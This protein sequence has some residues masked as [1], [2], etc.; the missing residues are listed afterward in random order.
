[1]LNPI[2]DMEDIRLSICG[3]ALAHPHVAFTLRNES[4]GEK[5]IQTKKCEN[6]AAVFAM[7][8]G[9]EWNNDADVKIVSVEA[10]RQPC[11]KIKSQLKLTGKFVLNNSLRLIKASKESSSVSKT[12]PR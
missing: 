3:I 1:M 6:V 12:R 9:E 4:V 11:L 7:L 10:E 8:F 5:L 2:L